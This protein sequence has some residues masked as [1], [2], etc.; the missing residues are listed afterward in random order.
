MQLDDKQLNIPFREYTNTKAAI[1]ALTGVVAGCIAYATDTDELGTYDGATWN[2][3]KDIVINTVQTDT[4]SLPEIEAPGTPA[5]NVITIYNEEFH[6]FGF[7]N[8]KDDTDMVRK[9]VRDNVFVARADEDIAVGDAVYVSNQTGNVPEV[10]KAKADSLTTMPAVGVAV[11]AFD[12]GDYGRVMMVGLL[13]N[14]DTSLFAIGDPLYVSAG[15]AGLLTATAPLYPNI[16]QEIGL[17]LVVGV[18]NGAMQVLAKSLVNEGV[19]D[20]GGLLGLDGD[21]HE[22]YLLADGTR[23]LAGAWDMGDQALTNVNIDSSTIDIVDAGDYYAATTVEGALQ[24]VGAAVMVGNF[25][26]LATMEW[27]QL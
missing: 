4:V 27:M 3:N 23:A 10:S 9:L 14:F 24:E 15:T 13:E 7:L 6:G 19:I 2:W 17:C 1:E 22:Q 12:D 5:E 18:G 26:A 25:V 11:E 21:D 20:H 16:R 8:F